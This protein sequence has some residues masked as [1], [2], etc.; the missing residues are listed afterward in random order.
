MAYIRYKFSFFLVLCVFFCLQSEKSQASGGKDLNYVEIPPFIKVKDD[1]HILSSHITSNSIIDVDQGKTFSV[2]GPLLQSTK[3]S[4]YHVI[5][6]GMGTIS[7]GD[8]VNAGILLQN[9]NLDIMEDAIMDSHII[10]SDGEHN[11]AIAGR[12]DGNIYLDDGNNN[13]IILPSASISEH[14]VIRG[15]GDSGNMNVVMLGMDVGNEVFTLNGNNFD[16]INKIVLMG[17]NRYLLSNRIEQSIHLRDHT[18]LTYLPLQSVM[19]L[20]L[21]WIVPD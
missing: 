4:D 15:R 11:I 16:S 3:Y 10:T 13:I 14:S 19:R 21:T 1:I 7:L 8:Y 2:L 20:R 12:L 9:G 6:Q 18:S 5:K 17:N